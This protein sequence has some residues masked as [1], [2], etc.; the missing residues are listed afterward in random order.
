M[1]PVI[2]II[3]VLFVA[4]CGADGEPVRPTKNAGTTLMPPGSRTTVKISGTARFG[5]TWRAR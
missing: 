1:K 4:G 2:A 3:T 5:V